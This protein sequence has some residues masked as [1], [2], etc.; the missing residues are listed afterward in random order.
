MHFKLISFTLPALSLMQGITASAIA[1]RQTPNLPIAPLDPSR[2]K[3]LN[4]PVTSRNTGFQH[5]AAST[6]DF[7]L[8]CAEENC[9]GDCG[10]V[11][12]S[13]LQQDVC[14]EPDFAWISAAVLPGN[15]EPLPFEVFVGQLGCFTPTFKITNINECN[16]LIG[17]NTSFGSFFFLPNGAP[18]PS[19]N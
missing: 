10:I 2:V 17:E 18:G 5:L 14:F 9:S 8:L 12:I 4:I 19:N 13:G 7:L 6:D 11:D 1:S 15:S 16:D 3:S